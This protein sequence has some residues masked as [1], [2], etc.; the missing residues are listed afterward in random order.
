MSAMRATVIQALWEMY[1]F[2]PDFRPPDKEHSC[3][4]IW[5][6]EHPP[7]AVFSLA[8]CRMKGPSEP[9]KNTV[10]S[11]LYIP[12]A[13]SAYVCMEGWPGGPLSKDTEPLYAP[14]G[15]SHGVV[16]ITPKFE[17]YLVTTPPYSEANQIVP[18]QQGDESGWSDLLWMKRL[19]QGTYDRGL[20]I[21]PLDESLSTQIREM[22]KALT[23]QS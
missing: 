12:T 10:V 15:R 5:E 11:E 22:T 9:H 4:Q 14:V 8:Y 13:G 1:E 20:N 6:L 7:N 17:C 21:D 3:G 19:R 18:A 2:D 23:I 16:P